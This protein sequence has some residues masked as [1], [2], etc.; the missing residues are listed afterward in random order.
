MSSLDTLGVDGNNSLSDYLQEYSSLVID[1]ARTIEFFAQ[2]DS[3]K[4]NITLVLDLEMVPEPPS[5]VSCTARNI[6]TD[7]IQVDDHLTNWITLTIL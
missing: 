2:N 1:Y 4:K 6:E 3:L 7:G 5:Q